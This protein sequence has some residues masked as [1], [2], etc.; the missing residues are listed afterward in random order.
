MIV[1][2]VPQGWEVIFQRAHELLAQ[3]I[4]HYWKRNQRPRRWVE[5]LSAIGEHDNRQEG[6]HERYHLTPA[7]APRDFSMQE[8]SYSQAREVTDVTQYKSRYVSLLVSMHT[9]YLYEPLRGKNKKINQFLDDQQILQKNWLQSLQIS[10]EE[11]H[12][13]YRLLHWADRC[14]LILCKKELPSHE[15]RLE[16]FQG[17]EQEAYHIWQRTD[18]SLAVEPWPFEQAEFTVW[19]ESR[20]LSQLRFESDEELANALLA[21]RVEEQEWVFRQP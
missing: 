16:V 15:R 11:A 14:S 9:S 4:A 12:K 6:W 8:F 5:L 18:R 1:N 20:I 10:K 2:A 21:A 13:G 3:Q 19:V 17:P 7:G